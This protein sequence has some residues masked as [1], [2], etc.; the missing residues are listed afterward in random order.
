M[1]LDFLRIHPDDDA[2]VALRDIPQ[3]TETE[4]AGRRF[5]TLDDIPMGHKMALRG[6][7]AGENVRKYGSPIGHVTRDVPAGSWLHSH[8]LKTTR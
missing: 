6:L 2:A 3:H 5:V 7:R 8:N 1:E 4:V